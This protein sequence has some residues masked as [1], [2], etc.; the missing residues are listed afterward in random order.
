MQTASG[1][2]EG[3]WDMSTHDARPEDLQTRRRAAED[4]IEAAHAIRAGTAIGRILEIAA[5][6]LGG[7]IDLVVHVDGTMNRAGC[8]LIDVTDGVLRIGDVAIP[9]DADVELPDARR[10]DLSE[11]HD[12]VVDGR[13]I[14]L[15]AGD[16]HDPYGEHS[17]DSACRTILPLVESG[18]MLDIRSSCGARGVLPG[19]AI[20]LLEPHEDG[21]AFHRVAV[22]MLGISLPAAAIGVRGIVD[23]GKTLSIVPL[24]GPIVTI[25]RT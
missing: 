24:E 10:T 13:S 7:R 4:R 2:D 8:D 25:R 11:R 20:A 18:A 23:D 22:P 14:V 16:E 6:A 9:L 3:R 5:C 17:F 1:K 12:F 19:D 15:N 21:E